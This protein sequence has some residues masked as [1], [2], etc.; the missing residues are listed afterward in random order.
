MN[1]RS[2]AEAA[3]ELK[4]ELGVR[5][6]CYQRWIADGKL[7]DVEAVDRMERMEKA[8]DV[9]ERAALLASVPVAA[10]AHTHAS[11]AGNPDFPRRI[12]TVLKR[13]PSDSD[14][15]WASKVDALREQMDAEPVT[16]SGDCTAQH[17]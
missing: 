12:A 3:S 9:V 16:S 14:A 10:P 4:R 2:I 6:R 5:R 11:A 15:E 7:T 17:V 1:N 13:L 8:L